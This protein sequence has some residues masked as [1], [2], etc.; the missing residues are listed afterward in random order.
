MTQKEKE[1]MSD[2]QLEALLWTHPQ[3]PAPEFLAERIIATAARDH[4]TPPASNKSF[5][6][7]FTPLM[8][9]LTLRPAFALALMLLYAGF[10]A[11]IQVPSWID[12]E[13]S[14]STSYNDILGTSSDNGEIL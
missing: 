2:G 7:I 6:G 9:A 4:T 5:R 11:G 12:G 8:R 10:F 14:A 1:V 13:I 3:P